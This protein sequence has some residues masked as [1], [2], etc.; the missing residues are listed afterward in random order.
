MGYLQ[1]TPDLFYSL[2]Y[3]EL[4]VMAKGKRE[5]DEVTIRMGWEQARMIAY[6]LSAP[7]FKKGQVPSPMKFHKFP[8]D[9]AVNTHSELNMELYKE[10]KAEFAKEVEKR[11]LK[12]A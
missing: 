6:K 1:L 2:T 10:L 8:W 5:Q 12:V 4:V 11:K 3:D 7:Y 9:D